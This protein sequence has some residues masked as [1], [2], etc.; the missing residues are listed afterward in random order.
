MERNHTAT[1]P[2]NPPC[3]SSHPLLLPYETHLRNS[4][5]GPFFPGSGVSAQHPG[6]HQ[7]MHSFSPHLL[8]TFQVPAPC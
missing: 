3:L 6:S 4:R 5:Q 1:L 8:N 2:T 7:L